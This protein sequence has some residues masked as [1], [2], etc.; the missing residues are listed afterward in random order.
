M[1]LEVEGLTVEGKVSVSFRSVTF[2]RLKC[3]RSLTGR[4][5]GN[6]EAGR[7]E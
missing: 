3:C 5:P 1:R 2:E 6:F 7:R 4:L